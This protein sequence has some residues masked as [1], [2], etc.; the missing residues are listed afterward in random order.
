MVSQEIGGFTTV[1]L[2]EKID[3]H[4]VGEGEFVVAAS[5]AE[6][7]FIATMGLYVCKAV[8]IYSPERQKGLLAHISYTPNLIETVS[9][10]CSFFGK[11]QD[12]DVKIV[13]TK[14]ADPSKG[15]PT[16]DAIAE[17]I[18][19]RNPSTITI[20][21]NQTDRETRGVALD[22]VNGQLYEADHEDADNWQGASDYQNSLWICRETFVGRSRFIPT[23]E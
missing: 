21:R 14:Q 11:L 12:A 19:D 18:A 1:P 3:F 20:D 6:R 8:S 5:S 17:V 23:S 15:W 2:T 4:A 10:L 22:L 7:P 13:Q 9:G 16:S